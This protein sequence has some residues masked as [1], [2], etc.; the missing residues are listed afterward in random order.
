MITTEWWL[1]L[2]LLIMENILLLKKP[3][4]VSRANILK[5]AMDLEMSPVAKKET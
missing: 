1:K 5:N 3:F 4:N 2:L